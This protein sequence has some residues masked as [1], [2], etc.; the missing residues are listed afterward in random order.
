MHRI[1]TLSPKPLPLSPAAA[2]ILAVV[3]EWVAEGERAKAAKDP[4]NVLRCAMAAARWMRVMD[5]F[6]QMER[7]NV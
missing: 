4:E 3:D 5:T 2:R 6:Q 7:N 1:F